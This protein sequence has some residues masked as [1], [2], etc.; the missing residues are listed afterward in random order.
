MEIKFVYYRE[1]ITRK[2]YY[3]DPENNYY[4]KCPDSCSTCE[5]ATKCLTCASSYLLEESDI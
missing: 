5:S 1:Y 2:E 3:K 4:Y